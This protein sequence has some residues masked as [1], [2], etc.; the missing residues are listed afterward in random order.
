MASLGNIADASESED[1]MPTINLLDSGIGQRSTT[2]MI[3]NALQLRT[4]SKAVIK[5]LDPFGVSPSFRAQNKLAVL[6]TA[7]VTKPFKAQD[8]IRYLD[9]FHTFV[10]TQND[11]PAPSLHHILANVK[12]IMMFAKWQWPDFKIHN[13]LLRSHIH[14]LVREKKVIKGVWKPRVWLGF[15]TMAR[16]A[17]T[18]LDQ[19]VTDG[20]ENMDSTIMHLLRVVLVS[21]MGARAGDVALSRGY[22]SEM[23][24]FKSVTIKFKDDVQNFTIPDLEMRVELEHTKGHKGEYGTALVKYHAALPENFAHIC[25]IRLLIIHALRQGLIDATSEQQLLSQMKGASDYTLVWKY[26]DY[27]VLCRGQ[28]G[29]RA[30]LLDQPASSHTIDDSIKTISNGVGFVGRIHSHA[31][32]LGYGRD[33]AHITKSLKGTTNTQTRESL[34]H[35]LNH[36]PQVTAQYVGGISEDINSLRAENAG[37]KHRREPDFAESE[38]YVQTSQSRAGSAKRQRYSD[39]QYQEF[40]TRHWK[41]GL[42]P[43]TNIDKFADLSDVQKKNVKKQFKNSLLSTNNSEVTVENVKQK[44]ANRNRQ[45]LM[46][47]DGNRVLSSLGQGPLDISK[48]A[49]V[50]VLSPGISP[51]AE[52]QVMPTDSGRVPLSLGRPPSGKQAAPSIRDPALDPRLFEEDQTRLRMCLDLL[53]P[54]ASDSDTSGKSATATDG[55]EATEEIT[56]MI[57]KALAP[58]ALNGDSNQDSDLDDLL[59]SQPPTMPSTSTDTSEP[60]SFIT[61]FSTYHICKSE[62]YGDIFRKHKGDLAAAEKAYLAHETLKHRAVTFGGSRDAPTPWIYTCTTPNCGRPFYTSKDLGAHVSRCTPQSAIATSGQECISCPQAGCNFVAKSNKTQSAA[63]VLAYHKKQVHDFVPVKCPVD[64]CD[65]DHLFKTQIELNNHRATKHTD[66]K[67]KC[68]VCSKEI[69]KRTLGQ[70]LIN[71][72]DMSKLVADN[73]MARAGIKPIKW[74]RQSCHFDACKVIAC[75]RAG[76]IKHLTNV[77]QMAEDDVMAKIRE[78][79]LASLPDETG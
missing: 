47:T 50:G 11:Q 66:N 59:A 54:A 28:N 13:E 79:E 9:S 17:Q 58:T 60:P 20:T 18:W 26:P 36:A 4:E 42:Y 21:S 53:L 27:P 15:A 65:P 67:V 35:A 12:A 45:V 64:G 14:H 29:S 75:D 31:M 68:P 6:N 2:A 38:S 32:R 69:L 23:L 34:G 8:V 39:D 56:D 63:F 1:D 37:K 52:V 71:M 70:H 10:E 72:H 30:L 62:T 16:L 74:L 46:P 48:S 49:S 33:V 77:H 55:P 61:Y 78:M 25:P 5:K 73:T 41:N 24:R 19:A 57:D 44:Q 40:L 51:P 43:G 3:D 22:N 76:H 7:D